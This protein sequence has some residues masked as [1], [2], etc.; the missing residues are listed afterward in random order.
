[1]SLEG[2]KWLVA[3][4]A[5]LSLLG[6]AGR[7]LGDALHVPGYF[8]SI[9]AASAA[10]SGPAWGLLSGLL[11][12]ALLI[13]YYKAYMIGLAAPALMGLI[14]G[15]LRERY[16]V[17]G[18]LAAALAYVLSWAAA[19]CAATGA[20]ARVPAFLQTRGAFILMLDAVLCAGLG[21]IFGRVSTPRGALALTLASLA[22]AGASWAVVQ[23]NEWG[24]VSRFSDRPGWERFHTKMDLVW[25]WMGGK[26][27]NNYYYPET[28][29][30]RGEP[31][32]Q[33]WVGLYWIQGRRDVKDVS[34]VSEFAV[35]DQNFWLGAHGAPDPYTYVVDVWNITE[36]E[37]WGHRAYLMYGGML[38]KS[39]VAPYEEVWIEGFFITFYDEELDRTGIVY[40]CALRDVL[41]EMKDELWALVRSWGS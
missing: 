35:W 19:Y 18:S 28:R 31:G 40:A 41:P 32:Y 37:F 8:D 25:I 29:F 16:R 7:L 11:S 14:Y 1:M 33:V 27:I 30:E 36:T 39:D 34:L 15:L 4:S 22:V 5:A 6:V 2:R 12:G 24:V 38:T 23:R 17:L 21:E 13:P 9:G 26:G 20:W 10:V 3:R